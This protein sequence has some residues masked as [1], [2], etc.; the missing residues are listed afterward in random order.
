MKKQ[1]SIKKKLKSIIEDEEE[2]KKMIE[3]NIHD[4]TYK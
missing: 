1:E 2:F 4:D 3:N